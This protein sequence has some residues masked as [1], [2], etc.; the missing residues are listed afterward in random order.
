MLLYCMTSFAVENNLHILSQSL[1]ALAQ[2][3]S[4]KNLPKQPRIRAGFFD[5]ERGAIP[6]Q[7][8]NTTI[9]LIQG[10]I[11]KLKSQQGIVV[12][13]IVNAANKGLAR[14][15][16]VCGAI[17][18]AAEIEGEDFL[19]RE[20]RN[21]FPRGIEPGSAIITESYGLAPQGIKKIIHAVGPI[22]KDY[23]NKEVAAQ[24]LRDAYFNSMK[25]AQGSNLSS[26]AFPFISS[27]IYGYPK[28]EA[29][30][31]ALTTIMKYAQDNKR[32]PVHD[33]YFVLFSQKDLNIFKAELSKI[34]KA[35]F[36]WK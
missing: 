21:I 29:A 23:K 33:V 14:G 27:A 9:H 18:N 2:K 1:D 13:A 16:G 11:T 8:N 31:I 26:I 6:Y 19:T 7:I 34:I 5:E 32:S 20:I 15:G 4:E 10:D 22:Y 25:L 12:D 3:L 17:F 24:V 36:Q 35:K 28:P 30:R